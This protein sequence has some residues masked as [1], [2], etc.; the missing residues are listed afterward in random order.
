M[1]SRASAGASMK[2]MVSYATCV[3]KGAAPVHT[4][5]FPSSGGA[6]ADVVSGRSAFREYLFIATSGLAGFPNPK[7]AGIFFKA[8]RKRYGSA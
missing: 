3:C 7:P 5:P 2:A 4:P 6:E 1:T 8:R